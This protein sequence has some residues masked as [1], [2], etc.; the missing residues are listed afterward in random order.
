MLV[1]NNPYPQDPRV[2]C[3]ARSLVE[4]GLQVCVIAPGKRSQPRRESIDGVCVYRYPRPKAG[5]GAAGYVWEY[6]YSL[7]ATFLLS[8]VVWLREG[9]DVIHAHNPPDLFVL[10]ALVFKPLRKKFVFDHHDLSPEMFHDRFGGGGNVWLFRALVLFEKLSCRLAD[11]VIATNA[12]YREVEMTRGGVSA[13]RVTIVRNGPDLDRLR[14]VEPDPDLRA[15]ASTILAYVGVMGYQDGIDY[16]L[17]ALGR[18]RDDLGRTDFYCVL[19][20]R[21]AAL[22]DL[23]KL[24]VK[25]RLDEQVWFTEYVPE[26]DLVRYLST[27]DIFVDPDPSSPFNDRSTMIKMMEYMTF[28]RPIVAFD[29]PE[30]RVTAGEAALYAAANNER[31]LAKCIARLMDDPEERRVMGDCGRQRVENQLAWPHQAKA[32]LDVYQ[33]LGLHVRRPAIAMESTSGAALEPAEIAP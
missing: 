12:S 26:E 16:L 7:A 19:M 14:R 24:A 32:L 33:Q 29:L 6:G 27:A 28:A 5:V 18:L 8:I 10:I 11:H 22:R 9:F 15:R 21:G 20:G 31:E 1:E 17:R 2:R 30:H 4:A 25:L 23:Q 3:E 13:E